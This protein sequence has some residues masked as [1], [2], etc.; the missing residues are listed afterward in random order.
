MEPVIYKPIL[1][2][3]YNTGDIIRSSSRP[4]KQFLA[5]FALKRLKSYA[6]VNNEIKKEQMNRSQVVKLPYKHVKE[7]ILMKI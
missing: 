4:L 3:K 2:N 6:P 5:C 7:V 1:F